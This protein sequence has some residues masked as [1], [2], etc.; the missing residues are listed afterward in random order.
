MIKKIAF[1][2]FWAVFYGLLVLLLFFHFYGYITQGLPEFM[3]NSFLHN[4][5]WFILHITFGLIV[6]LIGVFQFTP[7]I[8]NRNLKLHR[9]LGKIYILSSLICILSLYVIL[10]NSSCVACKPSQYMVTSLWLVFVLL[11][12]LSIRQRKIKHHRRM[13]VSS[14]ICA[15]YFVSVRIVGQFGMGIFRKAFNTEQAQLLASDIFC[16]AAPLIVFHIYWIVR[17]SNK[18]LDK[19]F[20]T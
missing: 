2:F 8:R 15:A 7:S 10:P 6:Y 12:Y 13:M 20:K 11:A 9:T 16:W 14:F 18:G 17:T 19:I 3:G 1:G 5:I 4:Q